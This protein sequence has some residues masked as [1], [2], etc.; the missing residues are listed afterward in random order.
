MTY[1]ELAEKYGLSMV[2][3]VGHALLLNQLARR[4]RGAVPG[5]GQA[6]KDLNN[7]IVTCTEMLGQHIETMKWDYRDVAIIQVELEVIFKF[8]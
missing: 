5:D 7:I 1:M 3:Y 8:T 4:V 6:S 2:E